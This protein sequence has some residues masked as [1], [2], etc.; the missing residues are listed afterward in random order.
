MT[1][2]VAL[3]L[4]PKAANPYG[5]PEGRQDAVDVWP[6][7]QVPDKIIG[8]VLHGY[9]LVE[10]EAD[11][12]AAEIIPRIGPEQDWPRTIPLSAFTPRFGGAVP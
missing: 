9:S 8:L 12:D 11:L 7:G 1:R 6:S 5:H 4:N 10:G 3:L 2:V